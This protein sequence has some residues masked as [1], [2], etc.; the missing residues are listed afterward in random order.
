[1]HYKNIWSE[2]PLREVIATPSRFRRGLGK[3]AVMV[4]DACDHCLKCVVVCP[5][6]V[7]RARGNKLDPPKI[8]CASVLSVPRSRIDALRIVLLPRF[9]SA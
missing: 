2:V 8:I 4:S 7:F 1:M 5:E 6:N 9:E 3:Y